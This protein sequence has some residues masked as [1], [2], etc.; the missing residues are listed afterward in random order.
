M[1]RPNGPLAGIRVIELAGLGPAPFG[2]TLL[3]DLGA[4]VI[5]ID[6]PDAT[7]AGISMAGPLSRGRRS[8]VLDLKNPDDVALALELVDT[9]DVLIDPFRPGVV[10]RLGLGP[11]VCVAR[12][13]RLVYAHMTG[14]GQDGPL[15]PRVGHDLNY[16]ALSGVL[17]MMGPPD[18]PPPPPLNLVAD[19]GGGGML[20]G[21]GVVAALYERERSG[22]GQVLDV[23]MMDGVLM[24]A[25]SLFQMRA[26]GSWTPDRGQ[27]ALDGGA[28]WYRAY[29]SAD[30]QYLTVAALE[31]QF[32]RRLLD[33]LGIDPDPHPQWDRVDWPDLSAQLERTFAAQPLQHWNELLG[34]IDVC[35]APVLDLNEL[36]RHPHHAARGTVDTS[37]GA[38]QPA[39][40]PRFS[41]TPAAVRGPSV[42]PGRHTAEILDELARRRQ[43]ATRQPPRLEA[44]PD[45]RFDEPHPTEGETVQ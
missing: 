28:P 10:H 26:D 14:W 39:P 9:A 1:T 19:F 34:D 45:P 40:A 33:T 43:R 38:R 4:D 18:A 20:L 2:A 6:R 30:G 5:R 35:Y 23:A 24:L 36:E 7:S 25:A 8:I 15:A 27:N 13:P 21:F 29:R 41:R 3:S 11:D 17:G 31:P 12:N 42:D 37:F 44:D 16:L 32:Y 22:R